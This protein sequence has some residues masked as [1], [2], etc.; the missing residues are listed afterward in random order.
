VQPFKSFRKVTREVDAI[1]P[2]N[3]GHVNFTQTHQPLDDVRADF[4][5]EIQFQTSPHGKAAALDSRLPVTPRQV[6]DA[7]RP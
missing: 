2:L 6:P 7:A 5:V 3:G 1:A 4:I